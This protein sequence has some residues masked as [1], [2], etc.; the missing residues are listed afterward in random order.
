MRQYSKRMDHRMFDF[1]AYY[2]EVAAA[3]PNNCIL[4]EVGVAD[5]ASAIYLA[6]TLV[7]MGKTFKLY[8]IDSLAYGGQDQLN[9]IIKHVQRAGLSELCEIVAKDSLN[10]SCQFA[11]NHFDFVF[12]DASHQYEPTK[13]DI[14]LWYHK[15]KMDGILAGHDY[16]QQEG[17]GVFLAVR[18]VI[19]AT[20]TRPPLADGQTFPEEVV[21]N[22]VATEK[23]YNVWWL[24]KKFYL[25]L[26]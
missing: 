15:V 9:E 24:Q 7:E 26:K 23:E 10:A 14:R 19:P 18:E 2:D 21:R 3:L 25:T 12:I 16:N 20:F 6:E 5:G 13:A 22:I 8:L 17:Q 4:A 11:D 1:A